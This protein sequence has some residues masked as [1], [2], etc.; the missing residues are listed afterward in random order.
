[1]AR[2]GI[3]YVDCSKEGMTLELITMLIPK[4]KYPIRFDE[5]IVTPTAINGKMV[6]KIELSDRLRHA[7][8]DEVLIL[9]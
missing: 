4:E 8:D 3:Y 7:I 5:I 2:D 9:D 6:L 1:M